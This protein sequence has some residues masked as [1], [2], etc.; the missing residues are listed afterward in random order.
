MFAVVGTV[1]REGFPLVSGTVSVNGAKITIGDERVPVNRGTPALLAAFCRTSSTLGQDNPFAYLTGDTGTGEGSRKLY[2]HLAQD[3]PSRDFNGLV[4]HYIMPDLSGHR[5]TMEAVDRMEK[6]P[7]LAA[8]AGAMYVAK[9]AGLANRYD[10]LTPDLGELAFLADEA[11]PHPFYTRGFIMHEENRVEHLIERA[12]FHQNA[13]NF[14]MVKGQTD[15][16]ADSTGILGTVNS[17]W[18]AALE[19]IG[20]TGDTLTGVVSALISAGHD[21]GDACL[22]AFQVNR[23]AGHIAEPDPSTQV[24]RII[25]CIPEALEELGISGGRF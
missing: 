6:H 12:Y 7:F 5:Q 19:A 3:L 1:P 22:E 20:G 14:L 25:D 18:V 11:A 24:G 10:L 23:L 15:Y 4:L 16:L 2:Q 9:M 17:P 13:S 21:I 8:D